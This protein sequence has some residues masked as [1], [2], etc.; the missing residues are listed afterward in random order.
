MYKMKIEKL[1]IFINTEK[2][3]AKRNTNKQLFS[4]YSR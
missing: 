4:K 2:Q 1:R 3:K